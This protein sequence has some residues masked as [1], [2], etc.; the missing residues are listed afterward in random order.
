MGLLLLTDE[1]LDLKLLIGAQAE[2]AFGSWNGAG[3]LRG[4][5]L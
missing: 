2:T 1:L 3:C 4:T 5:R